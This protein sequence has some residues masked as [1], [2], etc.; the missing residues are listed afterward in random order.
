[1]K[2]PLAAFCRAVLVE[3]PGLEDWPQ[4]AAIILLV[5]LAVVTPVYGIMVLPASGWSG[6]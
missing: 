1:M 6:P 4:W 2:Y 5:V 3:R